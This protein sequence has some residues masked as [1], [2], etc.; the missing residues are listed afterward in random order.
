MHILYIYNIH[1]DQLSQG[2]PRDSHASPWIRPMGTR[3]IAGQGC[4]ARQEAI[5]AGHLAKRWT[6]GYPIN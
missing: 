5:S 4:V 2:I 1:I 6:K 3:G